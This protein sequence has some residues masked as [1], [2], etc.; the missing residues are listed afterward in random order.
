MEDSYVNYFVE[1]NQG[2]G[3]H[4]ASWRKYF[5]GRIYKES[6]SHGCV[7]SPLEFAKTVYNNCTVG[8][9]KVLVVEQSFLRHSQKRT[10]RR[11]ITEFIIENKL[12]PKYPSPLAV[13]IE[14]RPESENV[15]LNWG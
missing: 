4:D 11:L 2:I 6:G 13:D 3:I 8:S 14:S 7:N 12:R 15:G 9:T 1:F 5:G 10:T